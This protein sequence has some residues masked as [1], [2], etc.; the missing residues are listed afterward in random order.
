MAVV[1]AASA[2]ELFMKRTFIEP[3]LRERVFHGEAELGDVFTEA[4][5]GPAALRSRLPKLLKA[6]WRIDVTVVHAWSALGA[7]WQLRNQI[8]HHGASADMTTARRHVKSCRNVITALL[9][10]RADS[11]DLSR[12]AAEAIDRMS[13]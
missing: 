4:L 1:R 13:P 5:L 6:C 9:V 2:F 11:P 10:A 7:A 8:V 12:R 3:Y